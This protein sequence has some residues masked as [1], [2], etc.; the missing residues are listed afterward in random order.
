MDSSHD[1]VRVITS[2]RRFRFAAGELRFR[3][4]WPLG[5]QQSQRLRRLQWQQ[6]ERQRQQH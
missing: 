4:S 6:Q 1:Q 3:P 2:V 5:A